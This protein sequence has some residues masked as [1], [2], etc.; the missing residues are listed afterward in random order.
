M[1]VNCENGKKET[2]CKDGEASSKTA[3]LLLRVSLWWPGLV[4]DGLM[5]Q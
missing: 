2:C 5:S 4:A 1:G 3:N